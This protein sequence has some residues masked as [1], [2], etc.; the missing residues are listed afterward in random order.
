MRVLLAHRLNLGDLVCATPGLQ[1]FRARH[2]EAR[3][4]LLTNDFAAHVGRL[5]PGVEEVY[6]YRKFA[7][8]GTPEWRQLLSARGWHADR[9]IGLSPTP[10]R[11]LAFRLRLLGAKPGEHSGRQLHAAEQLAWLFGWRGDDALPRARLDPPPDARPGRDVA[12]WVSAR[13]PSNR[14]SPRQIVTLA[15][16]LRQCRPGVSIGVFALPAETDSGAHLPDREAQ[17]SMA[18]MLK[19]EGLPL[20][21][22]PLPELLAELASSRSVISPDGGIA[23]IAAGFGLPVVALFGD[24][25]PADWRPYSPRARVLQAATRRVEDLES[26]AIAAAWEEALESPA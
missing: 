12:I 10:D 25:D 22:P 11:R 1:W 21:T 6:S 5:L 26:A 9:V 4:R 24:V 15:G 8:R 2:P 13:K 18:S 16:M 19:A 3:F 7:A 23:H 20:L 17:D 14:P